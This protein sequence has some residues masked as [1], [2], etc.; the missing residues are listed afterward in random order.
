VLG[1]SFTISMIH[2]NVMSGT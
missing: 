2:S 1:T